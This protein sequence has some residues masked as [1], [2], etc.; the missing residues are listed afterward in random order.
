MAVLFEFISM[1]IHV[2]ESIL[3]YPAEWAFIILTRFIHFLNMNIHRN[4]L[5]KNS[6]IDTITATLY[7]VSKETFVF[8]WL[9]QILA[10]YMGLYQGLYQ[11]RSFLMFYMNI[12]RNK[13]S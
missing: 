6:D 8:L 4:K 12:T 3:L 1:Y 11:T 5:F 10:L 2:A 7:C 9:S 13:L